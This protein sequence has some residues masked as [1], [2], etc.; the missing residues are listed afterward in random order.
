ME[1]KEGMTER[2]EG[3]KLVEGGGDV[4]EVGKEVKEVKEERK[5]GRKEEREE[6]PRRKEVKEGRLYLWL[7]FQSKCWRPTCCFS[8]PP[9]CCL[10]VRLRTRPRRWQAFLAHF[11]SG[12]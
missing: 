7:S 6:R 2:S 11:R 5:K 12:G 9:S 3:R 8:E 10:R 1:E 4:K